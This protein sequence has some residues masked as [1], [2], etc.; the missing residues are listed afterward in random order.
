MR[1]A[2]TR[3]LA[4]EHHVARRTLHTLLAA[5]LLLLVMLGGSSSGSN[6]LLNPLGAART[7]PASR[8]SCAA[9]ST[10]VARS[11][12]LRPS[13][14]LL[15]T[16]GVG[17]VLFA[18]AA[19]SSSPSEQDQPD[20]LQAAAGNP[21]PCQYDS[22]DD[23]RKCSQDWCDA[24]LG[25]VHDHADCAYESF[26]TSP[27]ARIPQDIVLAFELLDRPHLSV[28]CSNFRAE[29]RGI[30]DIVRRWLA[31]PNS[32]ASTADEQGRIRFDA[33]DVIALGGTPGYAT[34]NARFAVLGYGHHDGPVLLQDFTS[35]PNTLRIVIARHFYQPALVACFGSNLG[36]DNS[37]E[38]TDALDHEESLGR[39]RNAQNYR[40]QAHTEDEAD[41]YFDSPAAALLDTIVHVV[42][43]SELTRFDQAQQQT[44]RLGFRTNAEPHLLIVSG[45]LRYNAGLQS[46]DEAS[47]DRFFMQA[48]ELLAA[49][50][51]FVPREIIPFP[52]T[53]PLAA[54]TIN[55]VL[56]STDKSMVSTFG[57]PALVNAYTDLSHFNPAV[58]LKALLAAGAS[59]GSSFLAYAIS[60]GRFCR[61]WDIE[62]LGL[63]AAQIAI[64]PSSLHPMFPSNQLFDRCLSGGCLAS[65]LD[66]TCDLIPVTCSDDQFCSPLHGCV[67]LS[68]A[69]VDS[70]TAP[71]AAPF[72]VAEE[73]EDVEVEVETVEKRIEHG[74]EVEEIKKTIEV[75]RVLVSAV[76]KAEDKPHYSVK[77]QAK[78][79]TSPESVNAFVPV[80][81]Y[82]PGRQWTVD[83][84]TYRNVRVVNWT[85]DKS[86][87]KKFKRLKE[88]VIL[89]GTVVNQWPA[90]T[91]WTLQYLS[92][93]LG[94]D[95]LPAVKRSPIKRFFDPDT[96]AP[97]AKFMNITSTY[98]VVDLPRSEFFDQLIASTPSLRHSTLPSEADL[99]RIRAFATQQAN[100]EIGPPPTDG[101]RDPHAG[102]RLAH[103]FFTRITP[104]LLPDIQSSEPMFYSEED[105]ELGNQFLWI[106]SAGVKTHTHFDQD[107]NAY[108]QITGR[109]RFT[110]FPPS[111]H[112]L[113][114]MFPRI[115]PMWHKSRVD[116]DQ[117]DLERFPLYRN[118][119]ALRA[120][121]E[122]GDLILIPPYTWHH[123]ESLSASVSLSTWSHDF[124]VY[125]NMHA[126]YRHDHMFDLLKNPRGKIYA[127]RLYIELL[128]DE[129]YGAN[130]LNDVIANLL[131][132]RYYGLEQ[133]F[134]AHPD[135][136]FMCYG[137]N[138][139]DHVIPSA[140]HILGYANFD[141]RIMAPHFRHFSA[142]TRDILFR[143]YLEELA[144]GVTGPQRVYAFFRYCFNGETFY[145]TTPQDAE[146][147]LW[148]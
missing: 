18:E 130:S 96:R 126:V 115:H 24:V 35:D 146:H 19:S 72:S 134:P 123:V 85:P 28:N 15:P 42:D 55:I 140:K 133:L 107:M 67:P 70:E 84:I 12:L 139:D 119:H 136:P 109:K 88:P 69:R 20:G 86:F 138:H 147:S 131:R 104:S 66:S 77:K 8:P 90:R 26:M 79:D 112:E 34:A 48:I 36:M 6:R 98:E 118:A 39:D 145:F 110:F 105:I 73:Y 23:Q 113:M 81:P 57:N 49:I 71:A 25:C 61:T 144:A 94:L 68:A 62:Q 46:H 4:L 53:K 22:C 37:D 141:V 51:R 92:A 1:A 111:E 137:D 117:P 11:M 80:A 32:P 44:T 31:P 63:S 132:T 43:G 29:S 127:L 9:P 106:S 38:D 47:V 103:G 116:F 101:S 13:S 76:N 108:A 50:P 135:D 93:Q 100:G 97:L 41:A 17:G 14:T 120:D 33:E 74:K 89:R 87:I 102:L 52:P 5:A 27:S 78:F 64:I 10:P 143:N 148:D 59:Q 124:A 60:K 99:N 128:V 40:D 30:M 129:V 58:T 54:P 2:A 3:G 125:D 114:Y 122:P 75:R 56:S 142:E 121:L 45:I 83:H 21:P 65:P 16:G 82:E 95:V 91:K 7:D